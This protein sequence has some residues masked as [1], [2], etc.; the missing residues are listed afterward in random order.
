MANQ[1]PELLDA[2]RTNLCACDECEVP[3]YLNESLYPFEYNMTIIDVDGEP[4]C[5]GVFIVQL[6]YPVSPQR[7]CITC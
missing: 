6:C 4:G 5:L 2:S 7:A 1:R 3:L